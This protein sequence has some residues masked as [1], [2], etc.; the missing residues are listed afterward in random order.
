M[1]VKKQIINLDR[2]SKRMTLTSLQIAAPDRD[3]REMQEGSQG[4]DSKSE[5]KVRLLNI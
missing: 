4:E 3:E 1:I 2:K 5:G